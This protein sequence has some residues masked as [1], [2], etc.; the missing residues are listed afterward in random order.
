MTAQLRSALRAVVL[1][2]SDA[3]PQD[4]PTRRLL[5]ELGHDVTRALSPQHAMELMRSDRTD[6]LV[7]DITN[8]NQNRELVSSLAELPESSQP[9]EVAIFSD[10]IDLQLRELRRRTSPK[11]H[12]FL[13]PLHMHGLLNVL[14]QIERNQSDKGLSA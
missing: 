10:V 3:H 14:R 11:M 12:I 1:P 7:I 13:K 9:G 2:S 6:L 5:D 8:N 4:T